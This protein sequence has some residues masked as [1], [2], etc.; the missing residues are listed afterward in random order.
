M[1][2][3]KKDWFI[4]QLQDGR[5]MQAIQGVTHQQSFKPAAVL[6]PVVEREDL[7]LILTKRASHLKHHAGQISFPGGRCESYDED[8]QQTALRESFEEIGL[9]EKHINIVS[10]LPT[11]NTVSAFEI[12][13]FVGLID[14]SFTILVDPNEVEEVFEVPLDFVLNKE[15]HHIERVSYK[16]QFRNVYVIQ[17][18]HYK[19]WGATAALI[20]TLANHLF[21]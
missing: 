21:P 15:N 11:Y 20:R 9:E 12:T 17:Y 4:N 10:Q 8:H 7:S 18:Q 19:I 14:P 1:L 13:P 2:R 5:P 3:I 16:G 6:I